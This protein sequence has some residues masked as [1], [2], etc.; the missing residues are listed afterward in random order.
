MNV[1]IK[2]KEILNKQPNFKP[3]GTRKTAAV[4]YNVLYVSVQSIWSVVL[5]VF[6]S[7]LIFCPDVLSVS[8]SVILKSPTNTVLLSISPFSSV[9]V[10]FIYLD[11]LILGEYII[12]RLF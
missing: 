6:V 2:K 7:L 10:R 4:G 8:E 11:P 1:Y 5:F 9:N 12:V 3:Q